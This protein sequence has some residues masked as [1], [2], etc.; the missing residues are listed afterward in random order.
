[1]F[2]NSNEQGRLLP[3]LDRDSAD[4]ITASEHLVLTSPHPHVRN[5]HVDVALRKDLSSLNL[6]GQSCGIAQKEGAGLGI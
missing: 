2:D 1:M 4:V 3:A 5:Q 6:C